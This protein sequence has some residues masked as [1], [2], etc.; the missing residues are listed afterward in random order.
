MGN[1]LKNILSYGG[2]LLISLNGW[3]FQPPEVHLPVKTKFYINTDEDKIEGKRSGLKEKTRHYGGL[4]VVQIRG[5]TEIWT[6]F[7][8]FLTIYLSVDLFWTVQLPTT[9]RK[10]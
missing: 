7:N 9:Q 6:T 10:S 8:K 4:Q 2:Y 5:R 3:D 1:C